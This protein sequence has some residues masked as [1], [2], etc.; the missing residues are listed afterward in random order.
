MLASLCIL[1]K[2]LSNCHQ[3]SSYAHQQPFKKQHQEIYSYPYDF[4]AG[5]HYLPLRN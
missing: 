4:N 3:G 1:R 2:R 5:K